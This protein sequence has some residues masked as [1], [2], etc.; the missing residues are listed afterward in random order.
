MAHTLTEKQ[1]PA[2]LRIL[3]LFAQPNARVLVLYPDDVA[4]QSGMGHTQCY[5][6]MAAMAEAGWLT[7]VEGAKRKA[8][9]P[10]PKL[11]DLVCNTIHASAFAGEQVLA[12][13]M[14][15][16]TT[17]SEFGEQADAMREAAKPRLAEREGSAA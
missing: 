12:Q 8:Y 7:E 5:K 14:G 6:V 17:L 3:E 16:L 1:M 2:A 11:L 13:V 10:G 9:R 4:K 15:L